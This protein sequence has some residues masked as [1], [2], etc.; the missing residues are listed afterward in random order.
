MT[1]PPRLRVAL[2]VH[3]YGLEVGGGAETLAR[4]IA[5]LLSDAVDLTVLTTCALDYVTWVDH[6]PPGESELNGVRILRFPVPRPRDLLAFDRLS[7]R[8]YSRPNDLEL[9]TQW[10]ELQGP[11]SPELIEHL[12]AAG[13]DYDVVVFMTYLYAT[14]AVGL[15]LVADRSVLVPTVHDEPPLRLRIFDEVFAKAR[16]LVFSTP[17][18]QDLAERRFGLPRERCRVIGVGVDEPP[19]ADPQRFA[20]AHGISA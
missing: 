5:E 18:E 4:L 3:R 14:T 7:E 17:E 6:L 1:A 9:G 10:M 20:T 2:V 16:A 8:A 13:D 12:R 11:V 19:A 15:P